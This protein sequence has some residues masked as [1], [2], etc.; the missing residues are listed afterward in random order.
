[1]GIQIP[2]PNTRIQSVGM[3]F[4]A[5]TAGDNHRWVSQNTIHTKIKKAPQEIIMQCGRSFLS[6]NSIE[7]YPLYR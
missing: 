1:M 6:Q 2:F 7:A 5:D 4:H 3:L